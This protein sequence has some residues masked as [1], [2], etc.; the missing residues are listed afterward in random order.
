M[1]HHLCF[2]IFN[3]LKKLPL[4][5]FLRIQFHANKWVREIQ[6][7]NMHLPFAQCVLFQQVAQR[8]Q[9]PPIV[10]HW[11]QVACG[12]GNLQLELKHNPNNYTTHREDEEF[13]KIL[14]SGSLLQ[15][16]IGGITRH[17]SISSHTP[18]IIRLGFYANL[19]Q[20][21]TLLTC[22]ILQQVS[23]IYKLLNF[24]GLKK[25]QDHFIGLI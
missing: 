15:I 12:Q 18:T 1:D 25:G 7:V 8:Q 2:F 6:S 24:K 16:F 19:T 22:W 9:D 23:K 5:E 14:L 17:Q 20:I 3:H 13:F 10:L 21:Q 4:L 11:V